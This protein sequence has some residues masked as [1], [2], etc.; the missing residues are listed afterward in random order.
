[1]LITVLSG[2]LLL[3][4]Q[5]APTSKPSAPA[6][7]R[8][9]PRARLVPAHWGEDAPGQQVLRRRGG[10]LKFRAIR[11]A[12]YTSAAKAAARVR[13][14]DLVIGLVAGKQAFAYP[15]NMLG[16]PHREIINDEFAGVRFAVN[17]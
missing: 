1:M 15:V 11:G 2:C 8:D 13:D 3:V 6:A 17:W 5:D 16:G 10:G 4:P 7:R 14:R 12:P 9:D